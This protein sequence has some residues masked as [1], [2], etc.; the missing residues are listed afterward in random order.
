MSD[1]GAR[2]KTI[3]LLVNLYHHYPGEKQTKKYSIPF[4]KRTK[5]VT[6]KEVA[7]GIYEPED[8]NAVEGLQFV[9]DNYDKLR[10]IFDAGDEMLPVKQAMGVFLKRFFKNPEYKRMFIRNKNMASGFDNKRYNSNRGGW[11]DKPINEFKKLFD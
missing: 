10:E 2:G 11:S 7:S 8:G 5:R 9:K 1:K 3:K 6:D 4:K